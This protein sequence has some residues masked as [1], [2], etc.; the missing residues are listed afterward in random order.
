MIIVGGAG[1]VVGAVIGGDAG[2]IVMIAG[3]SVALLGLW[4]YLS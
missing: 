1:L 3:G 2:T 4:R